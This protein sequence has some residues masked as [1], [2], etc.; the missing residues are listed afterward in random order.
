M[1]S[2]ADD[3]AAA[4]DDQKGPGTGL[5][6]DRP[7]GRV[8]AVIPLGSF[9]QVGASLWLYELKAI[10]SP[11]DNFGF[12]TWHAVI[13]ILRTRFA[14]FWRLENMA[15]GAPVQELSRFLDIRAVYKVY[16]NRYNLVSNHSFLVEE[17]TPERL[18]TYPRFRAGLRRL[19]QA[20]LGQCRTYERI[21][22]VCKAM[23]WPDPTETEV[24]EAQVLDLLA[25]LREL[26]QG[27]PFT[28]AL[29]VPEKRFARLRAWVLC[30]QI[31]DLH[32]ACWRTV[33]NDA[34]HQEWEDLLCDVSVPDDHELYCRVYCDLLGIPEDQVSVPAI[35]NF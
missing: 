21:R 3:V 5:A 15:I 28:L 31:P 4:P 12:K 29:A 7:A 14:D 26:R 24:L 22:F 34:K 19:E 32:I 13:P 16:C 8:D 27:K 23:N 10:N 11:F 30:E 18:L 35:N 1:N 25:V 33:W 17:N 9:C 6:Q 2:T 20:F